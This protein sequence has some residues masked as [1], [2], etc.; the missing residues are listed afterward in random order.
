MRVLALTILVCL[1]T[2]CVSIDDRTSKMFVDGLHKFGTLAA[3]TVQFRDQ[4][5]RWPTS[6]TELKPLLTDPT[7]DVERI[8][9]IVSFRITSRGLAFVNRKTNEAAIVIA[10]ESTKEHVVLTGGG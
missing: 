9:Q 7:I 1:L 6:P 4:N 10:N 5:G 8:D 3:T 2:S